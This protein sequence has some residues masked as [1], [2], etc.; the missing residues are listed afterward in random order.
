M[1]SIWRAHYDV[2]NHGGRVSGFKI[3][4]ENPWSKVM[5]GLLGGIPVLGLLSGYFFHPSYLASLPDGTPVMRVR[6]RPAFLEGK[7]TIERISDIPPQEE[8][9]LIYSFLM[10]LLLERQ[11]G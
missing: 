4:E 6:K 2:F 8:T 9:N 10:L 3:Q 7:F 5:D 1:K 11:R